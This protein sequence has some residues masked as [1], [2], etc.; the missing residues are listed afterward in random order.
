MGAVAFAI[1]AAC[2]LSFLGGVRCGFE[3]MRA[4]H[5]PNGLRLAF[6][7]APTLAGWILAMLIALQPL[8]PGAVAIFT[9]PFALQYVWDGRSASDAGAPDWYPMLRQVLTGGV[10]IACLLLPFADVVRRF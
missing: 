8:P 9:G 2:L 7:A 6:S 5:A 1:Y 3:L 4:P 10:M